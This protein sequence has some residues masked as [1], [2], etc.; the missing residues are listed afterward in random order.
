ME[1]GI[2]WQFC[3]FMFISCVLIEAVLRYSRRGGA[4]ER[5]QRNAIRLCIMLMVVTILTNVSLTL[6]ERWQE[7]KRADAQTI[8]QRDTLDQLQQWIK[9]IRLKYGV[10]EEA[11]V[12]EESAAEE[13]DENSSTLEG[14]NSPAAAEIDGGAAL[15][16]EGVVNISG[17]FDWRAIIARCQA[18]GWRF[19]DSP[20]EFMAYAM[21]ESTQRGDTS[22]R[23]SHLWETGEARYYGEQV[24]PMSQGYQV[25]ADIFYAAW[26]WER[27][28][29]FRGAC[30]S[31][32]YG[33]GIEAVTY[34]VSRGRSWENCLATLECES[35]YGLGGSI[36]FGILYDNYPNTLEGYC[37][38]LNDYHVTNDPWG[39]AMFW[40]E[41]GYPTYQE[42]FV[43]IVET[44]KGW[45][46]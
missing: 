1:N 31:E 39:Q 15:P 32:Y 37:D 40:N 17:R 8:S 12:T 24:Y 30:G 27:W 29:E 5:R 34:L 6:A 4:M 42:G 45:R 43:R 2:T 7:D 36:D 46:P 20:I 13:P 26:K 28:L 18:P 9:E 16:G 38:L 35:T 10:T 19:T 41:P 21:K 22:G 11:P 25:A 23:A 33:Q 3:L 44:I 14:E